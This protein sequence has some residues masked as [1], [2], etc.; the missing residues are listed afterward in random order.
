MFPSRRSIVCFDMFNENFSLSFDGNINHIKITETEYDTD[1]NCSFVFWFKGPGVSISSNSWA[2]LGSTAGG[3]LSKLY[4]VLT[5]GHLKLESDTNG[6]IANVT[7]N[8]NFSDALW[9]H[10][11]VICTSGTLTCFQDGVS[12]SVSASG[13]GDD[14]TFDII[15]GAGAT[16][17]DNNLYGNL[18]N[19]ATYNI[20]L[21]SAQITEIYNGKSNYNHLGGGVSGNLLNW[22]RVGDTVYDVSTSNNNGTMAGGMTSTN[23]SSDVPT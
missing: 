12:C 11:A 23:F 5:S 15:G 18:Y 10:Y 9:H 1:G 17:E 20:A 21:S 22:W 13:M 2:I 19:L 4:F 6:D 3:G 14:T 7:L 8:T 16:G